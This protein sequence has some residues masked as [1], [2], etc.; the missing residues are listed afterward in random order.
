M[1][2]KP[3]CCVAGK[4]GGHIIPCLQFAK[5]QYLTPTTPLLFISTTAALDKKIVAQF[6]EITDHLELALRNVPYRAG[7]KLPLF[8][9]SF[10]RA[11]WKSFWYLKKHKPSCIISTGGFVALPVCIAGKLLRIPIS[12]F[13]L[14][15]IPGKAVGALT[16]LATTVFICFKET[17]SSIKLPCVLTTYPLRFSEDDKKVT[18]E[19]AKKQIGFSET[20]KMVLILGGSQGSQFL[21][22]LIQQ[23]PL[24]LLKNYVVVHQTGTDQVAECS[25]FY[26]RNKIDAQIF[27]YQDNLALYYQAADS[28]I[29]RAG[30]GTL[31]EALFF[32]KQTI[33]IPLETHTTD[34]QL[35]NAYAMQRM[36]PD[37]FFVLRQHDLGKDPELLW[38]RLNS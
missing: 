4:S 6:P 3:I 28:I 8:A 38:Q 13:E 16:K 10:L 34:H 37:L 33:V 2:Q 11:T 21:N 12:L 24:S 14:N 18:P 27:A 35:A 30:A 9:F 25:D 17:Q 31:F 32:E 7:W 29:C 19:E 23:I 36:R 20:K 5:K 15:V 22:N 26:A 1:I